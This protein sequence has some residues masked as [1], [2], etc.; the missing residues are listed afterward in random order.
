MRWHA[1]IGKV[2]VC[3]TTPRQHCRI[4]AC[5]Q[6]F[7]EDTR[8][9]HGGGARGTRGGKE[10]CHR[11]VIWRCSLLKRGNIFLMREPKGLLLLYSY[12]VAFFKD[13]TNPTKEV[14]AD[15]IRLAKANN[16]PVRCFYFKRDMKLAQH[17]NLMRQVCSYAPCVQ[18][19]SCLFW[20][21]GSF[22]AISEV[23]LPHYSSF[24][25]TKAVLNIFN[26]FINCPCTLLFRKC[27]MA[28]SRRY[29]ML[30]IIPF[31]ESSRS[32]PPPRDSPRCLRCHLSC[33]LKMLSSESS[34]FSIKTQSDQMSFFSRFSV[35][36]A[37]PMICI[38][39][40]WYYISRG[41]LSM[42]PSRG[43]CSPKECINFPHES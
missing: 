26:L 17:L 6:R 10:R 33:T 12:S 37:T 11:Y 30:P 18:M 36:S 5:K 1:C 20:G 16:A 35:I 43:V 25:L 3:E 34:S 24:Y 31:V 7:V 27:P 21:G 28:P 38:V 19:H 40:S 22:F 2:I 39:F 13:N 15:Y 4:C 41:R 32:H 23:W 42:L 8:E 9:V 14:R 29:P